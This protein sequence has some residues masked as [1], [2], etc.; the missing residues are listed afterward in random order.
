MDHVNTVDD[1][2]EGL[3]E[4]L[5]PALWTGLDLWLAGWAEGEAQ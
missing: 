2:V 5:E 1:Y 3:L 4:E